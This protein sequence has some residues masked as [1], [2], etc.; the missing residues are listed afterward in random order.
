MLSLP[1][2]YCCST[3]PYPSSFYSMAASFENSNVCSSLESQ[4]PGQVSYPKNASYGASISSYFYQEARLAP[5]CIVFPKIASDISRN[6]K[7]I[8]KL[9]AKATVRGGGHAPIANAANL[10]NAIIID[11]SGM[12]TVSL[13]RADTLGP[14]RCKITRTLSL[15]FLPSQLLAIHRL[16]LIV[17]APLIATTL[18]QIYHSILRVKRLH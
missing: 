9:R 11:L 16:C 15:I 13:S 10:D 1:S 18:L 5:Q 2:F 17:P 4:F 14:C 3:A 6:I 8:S 12:N 7:T